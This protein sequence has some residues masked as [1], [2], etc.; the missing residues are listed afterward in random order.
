MFCLGC[1]KSAEGGSK[2]CSQCG[3]ALPVTTGST[4]AITSH[5]VTRAG[6]TFGS[7]PLY[8]GFWKRAGAFV[9]D[10]LVLGV[11]NALVTGIVVVGAGHLGGINGPS[12]ELPVS[13]A[14]WLF[15]WLY[16]ALLESSRYQ[17]TL[18]KRVF[19]IKVVDLA[20]GRISFA[21]ATGRYFGKILSASLLGIGYLM[22]GFT[23]R[24]QALHDKLAGCLVVNRATRAS[25]V[26]QAGPLGSRSP[27]LVV[28]LLVLV[29]IVPLI[30]IVAAIVLPAYQD[31]VGQARQAET[32]HSVPLPAEPAAP[33]SL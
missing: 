11:A 27:G 29:G 28:A 15:G 18:G 14:I 20:G 8:A 12:F 3:V 7:L 22:A 5:P 16:F 9:V 4:G 30:G 6:P 17:A 31:Y 32:E 13:L 10:S 21:H 25:D 19:D 26:Q 1:G 2:F 24:K 33:R 23:T